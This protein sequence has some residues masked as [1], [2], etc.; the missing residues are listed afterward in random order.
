MVQV[1]L[2]AEM[3]RLENQQK[4]NFL[5]EL[6]DLDVDNTRYLVAKQPQFRAENEIVIAPAQNINPWTATSSSAAKHFFNLLYS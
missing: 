6:R 2:D 4:A 3:E 5:T 1:L